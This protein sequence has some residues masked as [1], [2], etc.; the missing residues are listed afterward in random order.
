VIS[1]THLMH[2][3]IRAGSDPA[4]RESKRLRDLVDVKSLLEENP[5]LLAELTPAERAILDKLS[6]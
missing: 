3:K 4:R 5:D 6:I 2:E 1:I